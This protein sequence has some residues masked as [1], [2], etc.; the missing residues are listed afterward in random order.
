MQGQVVTASGLGLYS[1]RV[2]KPSSFI[3]STL[4]RKSGD[5]D[6]LITGPPDAV[7]P[8]EAVPLRYR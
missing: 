6:V 7:P 2:N 1:A 8:Y 3:I 5:F 4:G